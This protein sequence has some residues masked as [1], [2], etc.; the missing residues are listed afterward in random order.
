MV[1]ENI[2]THIIALTNLLSHERDGNFV[3]GARCLPAP[4][5]SGGTRVHVCCI[6]KLNSGQ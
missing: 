2:V 1:V 3:F 4:K 6:Y 5:Y